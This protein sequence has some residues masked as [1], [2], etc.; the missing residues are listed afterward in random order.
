MGDADAAILSKRIESLKSVNPIKIILSHIR[1]S[2]SIKRLKTNPVLAVF[3][4][5]LSII[6]Q[7]CTVSLRNEH[8]ITGLPDSHSWASTNAEV[9][10]VFVQKALIIP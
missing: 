2:H 7:R 5:L 8:M 1:L 3:P 10:G 6:L 9:K 4:N